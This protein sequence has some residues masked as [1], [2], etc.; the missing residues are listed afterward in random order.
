MNYMQ[1]RNAKKLDRYTVSKEMGVSFDFYCDV[2]KG[3]KTF[4]GQ[5]LEKYLQALNNAKE[6]NLEK[7]NILSNMRR[8]YE[9]DNNM[10]MAKMKLKEFGISQSDLADKMGV[11]SLA[12]CALLKDF[13]KTSYE[14]AY[15]VYDYLNGYNQELKL[16]ITPVQNKEERLEFKINGTVAD[17]KDE[18]DRVMSK[19]INE[20]V[21]DGTLN[22]QDYNY[23]NNQ[24]IASM[25]TND[26]STTDYSGNLKIQILEFENK[27]LQQKLGMISKIIN[28]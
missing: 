13:T 1:R 10:S 5:Q 2:E 7:I 15:R 22:V 23:T 12:I 21:Q 3:L 27:I 8:F 26:K 25:S 16:D 19:P 20:V 11:S 9:L 4:N 18:I 17:I 14:L 24:N 28:M 6:L